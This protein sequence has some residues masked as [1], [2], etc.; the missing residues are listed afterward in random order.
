MPV[1]RTLE[2]THCISTA[3][4]YHAIFP[5]KLDWFY[6]RCCHKWFC[7]FSRLW[8]VIMNFHVLSVNYILVEVQYIF[9]LIHNSSLQQPNQY[10]FTK[11]LS[12]M[13]MCS[14]KGTDA[15]NTCIL[16]G[17]WVSWFFSFH[18]QMGSVYDLLPQLMISHLKTKSKYPLTQEQVGQVGHSLR[19]N[20]NFN[21]TFLLIHCVIVD[22]W[23]KIFMRLFQRYKMLP[24]F[25]TTNQFFAWFW[26][27]FWHAFFWWWQYLDC[28]HSKDR[29]KVKF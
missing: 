15:L 5:L 1:V 26:V 12:M 23:L 29:R 20:I 19:W 4:L 8:L 11:Y 9:I 21:L 10:A 3:A 7:L 16:T 18:H 2:K 22:F 13:Y 28:Q 24:L 25:L 17:K 14:W 6:A 27:I